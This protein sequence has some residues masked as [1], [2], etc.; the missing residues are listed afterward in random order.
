MKIDN[1][2]SRWQEFHD[3]SANN[4]PEIMDS[5]QNLGKSLRSSIK[6]YRQASDPGERQHRMDLIKQ[7][8]EQVVQWHMREIL[9]KLEGEH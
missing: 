4:R 5:V 3:W 9:G 2:L 1:Y 7:D 6:A 8:Y